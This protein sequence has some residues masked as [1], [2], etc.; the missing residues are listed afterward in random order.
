MLQELIDRL[1]ALEV[2]WEIHY[3][4]RNGISVYID[5]YHHYED[6]D[7]TVVGRGEGLVEALQQAFD[8]WDRRCENK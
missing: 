4:N 3:D 6:F 2:D 1:E 7:Y 8:H 5:T